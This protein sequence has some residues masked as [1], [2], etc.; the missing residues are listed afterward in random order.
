MKCKKTILLYFFLSPLCITAQ[1][2][3]LVTE[4]G[5]KGD[6][7]TSNTTAIQNAIDAAEKAGG[8]KV[9][10]PQGKFITGSIQLKTGVELQLQK[11]AF[12]LGSTKRLDYGTGNAAALISATGQSNIA[13]TGEG[14]I[15]GRGYE[16]VKDLFV[17]LQQG[18]LQDKQ[19]PVKAPE[20]GTDPS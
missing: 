2:L 19:W 10:V 13:I 6:S 1:H 16:V 15:D 11:N 12:L 14:V 3:F 4:Y 7:T 17:Q 20:E 9:I 5:A 8:G 18:I